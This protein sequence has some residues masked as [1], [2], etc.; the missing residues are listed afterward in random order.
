MISFI[1]YGLPRPQGSKRH[2]GRGIMVE[3]SK[4]VKDWRA[5]VA[6]AAREAYGGDLLNGPVSLHVRFLFPRPRSDYGTGKNATKLRSSA[7]LRMTKKP[8]VSKLV[9]AVEDA[10]TGVLWRDDSQVC[11]LHAG[12]GYGEPARCVISVEEV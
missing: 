10:L 6:S 5:G 3:S 4:H 7:P 9:R 8:D 1:V 11:D 12:K 2:V